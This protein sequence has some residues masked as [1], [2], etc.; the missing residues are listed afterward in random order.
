MRVWLCAH[1]CVTYAAGRALTYADKRLTILT[2]YTCPYRP[3]H[4]SSVRAAHDDS[5]TAS[6]PPAEWGADSCVDDDV[7]CRVEESRVTTARRRGI[8]LSYYYCHFYSE[9]THIS[10]ICVLGLG[11]EFRVFVVGWRHA[12]LSKWQLLLLFLL[13]IISAYE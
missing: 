12:F 7:V 1:A 2:T 8:S 9:Q 13:L 10:N 6:E 3:T 5:K 11:F 4:S